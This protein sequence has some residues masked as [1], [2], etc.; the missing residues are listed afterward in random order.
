MMSLHLSVWPG[1]VLAS[2]LVLVTAETTNAGDWPQ[3]LGPT[4][5][6]VSPEK[7]AAWKESPYLVWREP[8][9]EG[10]SS[11]VVA[12][13]RI[14]LQSKVAGKDAE[15]VVARDAATGKLLWR[16]EYP[17]AAFKSLY[18]NGPRATPAVAG[19]R[20][21]T[22]GI[23]G[24][25][26][27]FD[28]ATGDQVWQVDP[29]QKF[30]AKNLFFGMSCSPLVE[31]NLVLV[32]VGG[33]G[34]SVVAFDTATGEVKWQSQNDGASYS[35]PILVGQKEKRQVVFLTQEGLIGL[36]PS[37]GSLGWR[38][39]L[40][41]RLL[42]SST[43]P[44]RCGTVLLASSITAGSIG[45]ELKDIESR[46]EA[47]QLWKNAN[48]TSY[49]STPV[50]VGK[51][52]FYMVTGSVPSAFAQPKATLH[53]VEAKTGKDLWAMPK[54]VGKYHAS[55]LRTGDDKLLMLEEAGNLVLIEPRPDG[56]R[57]LARSK[58]CGETWAHPALANGKLYVRD[59]KEV[60]CLQLGE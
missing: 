57:E 54:V 34:A 4:R 9:G 16:K 37:D 46:L 19:G 58:V 53:C 20:V 60:L 49:F 50:S 56:Y 41:D 17:R 13:K 1:R 48:L 51:E 52:Q 38:V 22:F 6:A 7:I 31:G 11:P 45:L 36:N 10:N 40:K 23:T 3:W 47:T 2:L 26:S 59:E 43:T 28:A 55:L 42:E 39:P 12:G 14:F 32:N 24:I 29:L 18:G 30:G 8:V 5:D 33:K 25:L 27:C 44:A 21:Y 15:E 35:S